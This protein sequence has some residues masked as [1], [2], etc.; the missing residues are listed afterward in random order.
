M[1]DIAFDGPYGARLLRRCTLESVGQTFH[2]DGITKRCACPMAF[3]KPDGRRIDIKTLVD[4]F[5]QGRLRL[6]IGCRDAVCAAILIGPPAPDH[7]MDRI[8]VA[9]RI[10]KPFQKHCPDTLT[11]DEAIRPFVKGVTV[12][13]RRKHADLGRVDKHVWSDENAGPAGKRHVACTG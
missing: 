7:G 13:I 11:R 3:H 5:H 6:W 1:T 4:V 12:A 2:L 8:A 10:G 9:L